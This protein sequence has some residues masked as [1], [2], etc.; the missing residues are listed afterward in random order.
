MATSDTSRLP[1][2]GEVIGQVLGRVPRERQPLLLAIAERMAADRY[3]VWA[4]LVASPADQTAL[5]ACAAREEDIAAR[6]ERLHPDAAAVQRALR[7]ELPE[8]DTI[9]R[10]LFARPLAD[11][12]RIQAEGERLGAATW[13]AFAAHETDAARRVVLLDC[14][15]L[16]IAS[17]ETLERL[18]AAGVANTTKA[19]V[20]PTMR[21]HD[22][23]RMLDWL[24]DA[25]AFE[26][27][28][29]V[30]GDDG[31]IAHAQLVL[32]GGMIMLGSWR[33]DAWG[34]LVKTA[35][36]AGAVTQSVYVVVPEVDAHYARATAAGAEIVQPLED[37]AHGGRGY[38]ARD[39]EGQ[40]WSFG[41]YDPWA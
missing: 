30:P 5:R 2:V 37:K 26:R 20:I 36:Q 1:N 19:P 32:G 3:R 18:L 14:A 28:L 35:R 34:N 27:H 31:T 22:A 39:P 7:D 41:S 9:T 10:T 8:L 40:L 29:V 21:Y 4:T 23:P 17:A 24:C 13:T 33:D 12:L 16:E 15:Q 6:V 11:Q 25:F 38:A